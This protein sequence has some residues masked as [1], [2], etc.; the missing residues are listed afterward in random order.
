MIGAAGTGD[1]LK[2]PR[3]QKR[4]KD[5]GALLSDLELHLSAKGKNLQDQLPGQAKLPQS[6]SQ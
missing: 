2:P 6:I 1:A 3:V 5:T 4:V